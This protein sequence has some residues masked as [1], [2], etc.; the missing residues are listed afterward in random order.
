[1]EGRTTSE[2][3]DT[4]IKSGEGVWERRKRR[5]YVCEACGS[6]VGE[7]DIVCPSCGAVFAVS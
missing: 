6:D 1:M 7:K 4:S 3:I 5:V 2:N